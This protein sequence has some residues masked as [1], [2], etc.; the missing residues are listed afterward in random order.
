MRPDVTIRAL[1]DDWVKAIRARDVNGSL[2]NFAPDVVS[3]DL[4]DPLRYVGSD[5]VRTRLEAW[6]SSFQG[7]IGYDVRDL[8]IIASDEVAFCH[9]LNHVNGTKTDGKTIDMWWRATVCFREIDGK[10]I[11]THSHSSVPFDMDSGKA[12]LDLK[13]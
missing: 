7:T 2:A 10:W 13:P 9:S 12:S 1:I 5:S 3:F 8:N 4:I 6:F 11:V